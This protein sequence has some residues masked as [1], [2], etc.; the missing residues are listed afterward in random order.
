MKYVPLGSVA[1]IQL[2]K[3]LSPKAKTGTFPRAS[4]QPHVSFH[5][6]EVDGLIPIT[7]S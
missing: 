6:N 1:H 3:M 5:L 7:Y 4:M 2:G